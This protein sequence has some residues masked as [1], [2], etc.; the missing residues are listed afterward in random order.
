MYV[1]NTAPKAN[2]VSFHVI[3][4]ITPLKWRNWS[5]EQ[6]RHL[7]KIAILRRVELRF[8]P[9]PDPELS[10]SKTYH[11]YNGKEPPCKGSSSDPLQLFWKTALKSPLWYGSSTP[12]GEG[13]FL[14]YL[15][16]LVFSAWGQELL[17]KRFFSFWRLWGCYSFIYTFYQP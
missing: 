4:T 8:K 6:L 3:L 17:A 7:L 1:H 10:A 9:R 11:S 5:F 13:L 2:H 14:I 12:W 15:C 16:V